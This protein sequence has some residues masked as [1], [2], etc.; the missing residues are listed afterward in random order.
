MM[1]QQALPIRLAGPPGF[2]ARNA[3]SWGIVVGFAAFV[4]GALAAGAGEIVHLLFPA[5]AL[6][7]GITLY[8]LHPT[9]YLGFTW[10]LWFLTPE[11]RRIVDYQIGWNPISPVVI[12]PY[13][14]TGLT[15]FTLLRYLPHLIQR[16]GL[17]PFALILV[18]L[19]Y[20]YT[21]GLVRAGPLP[22]TYGLLTWIAPVVFGF[23]VA[24]GW[25][26]YPLY[27]DAIQRIFLWGVLA[28]GVYGIVQFFIVPPW[29]AYWM[30]VAPMVSI[31]RPEPFEVR[32]WSTM[33]APGPFALVMM[34]GLLF[35]FAARG[36]WQLIAGVPGYVG[37][38]LSLVR[39]A[40]LGWAVGALFLLGRV[41]AR[42]KVRLI[43]VACAIALLALPLLRLEAVA[44]KVTDK[45][46][47]MQNL[48]EDLS[49]R[50]RLALYRDFSLESLTN[51]VG[52]GIGSTNL[53]TKLA[54]EG[55]LGRYSTVDSGI[56]EVVFVLGW[57]G[58][59]LF[60]GGLGWLLTVSFARGASHDD[61][62][63]QAAGAIVLATLAMLLS[64][65]TLLGVGGMVFW[66]FL[67]LTLS[68]KM[69]RREQ[70]KLNGLRDTSAGRGFEG[71]SRGDAT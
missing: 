26:Q 59:V 48:E 53:A 12:A 51:V 37:F 62:A 6:V 60:V 10:W 61:L 45:F 17:F 66:S 18:G 16:P 15:A 57:P 9:L 35:A 34:A 30:E 3:A 65:N 25:R 14:V 63:A 64:S 69:F 70:R 31:G 20:G 39:S 19:D 13:L 47:T 38:L 58:T 44:E 41:Q 56:L 32:V 23:H 67:G 68:A 52:E 50:A 33:N 21:V 24:V 54:N 29:D 11:V 43:A 28:M 7:V 40:W 8:L 46:E 4:A 1:G 27:R 42:Q 22:A 36:R 71:T 49:W 55:Q 5:A 2:S